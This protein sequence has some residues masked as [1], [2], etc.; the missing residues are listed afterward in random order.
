MDWPHVKIFL[1]SNICP[2]DQIPLIGAGGVNTQGSGAKANGLH[3]DNANLA[4]GRAFHA[5][6]ENDGESPLRSH[7]EP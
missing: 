2:R 1:C 7:A 5:A 6:D 3:G 4:R